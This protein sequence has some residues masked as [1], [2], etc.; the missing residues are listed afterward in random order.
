MFN[1]KIVSKLAVQK[2]LNLFRDPPLFSSKMGKYLF[3]GKKK[4]LNFA[5]NDY[6]GLAD[7]ERLRSKIGKC[8]AEYPVSA[9]SS[10]LVSGNLKVIRE[11]ELKFAEH[12]GFEDAL[13]FPSG[14]QANIALG[15]TLFD[16]ED[17]IFYDKHVH[18]SLVNGFKLN[19]GSPIGFNHNSMSHLQKRLSASKS[20]VKGVFTE[21]LFSMDGDLLPKA[22]FNE[23]KK[24]FGFTATIDEAHSLGAMGKEGKGYA[25]DIADI[26]L[27]TFGKAFGLF[28]A[29]ALVPKVVREFLLNFASAQIYTTSLPPAHAAAASV[30]L[31]EIIMSEERRNQLA[32]NSSFL[33]NGLSSAGFKVSGDAHILSINIGKEELAANLAKELLKAGYFVLAARF[34]TIP[35]NKAILRLGMSSLHTKNEIEAFVEKLKKLV[36]D[37]HR[38]EV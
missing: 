7:D 25:A 27:G 37:N 6:L 13:F 17:Q 5:S 26:A 38:Y 14:F 10:R 28:G 32:A 18:A 31:D 1:Q 11:A 3:L 12:F 21:S 16:R 36:T 19:P 20:A 30:I 24:K 34:P 23:L 35:K 33:K 2:Q 8:F 29:I 4:I 22:K 15:S 9:S